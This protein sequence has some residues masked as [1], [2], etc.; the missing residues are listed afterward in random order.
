MFVLM[1]LSTPISTVFKKNDVKL[2]YLWDL[3]Y[4][5]SCFGFGVK[6]ILGLLQYTVVYHSTLVLNYLT[7]YKYSENLLQ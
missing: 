1:R 3:T 2:I 4:V 5:V 6:R 7:L